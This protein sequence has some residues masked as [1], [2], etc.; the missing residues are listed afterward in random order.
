MALK[1]LTFIFLRKYERESRNK[2]VGIKPG[3]VYLET[4]ILFECGVNS[5]PHGGPHLAG[6]M[7]PYTPEV[8]VL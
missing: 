6:L 3:A 5:P 1:Y 7:H 2:L 8:L 4:P